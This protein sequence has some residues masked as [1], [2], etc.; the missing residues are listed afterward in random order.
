M[1][2]SDT[3]NIIHAANYAALCIAILKPTP[4]TIEDAFELYEGVGTLI[5]GRKRVN[6]RERLSE[7]MALR[8]A[9]YTWKE[10][11]IMLGLQAPACYFSRHKHL[12]LKEDYK[13]D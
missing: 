4:V 9:G 5:G 7:M 13:N 12:L 3:N 2:R 10:V 1:I 11:G 8:E 6:H